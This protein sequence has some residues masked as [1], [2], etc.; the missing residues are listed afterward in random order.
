[1]KVVFS[2]SAV[3]QFLAAL[4]YNRRDN[5]TAARAFR[6]KVASVLQRLV[7]FPQSGRHIPEFPALETREVIIA[8]YRFFYRV[9][10]DTILVVA[11][12]H[13]AQLPAEPAESAD[14]DAG[15]KR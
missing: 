1:M 12:W 4:E 2:E 10:E 9:H 5:P 7:E 3:T 8:P 13:G 15:S 6:D 11:A 14:Q